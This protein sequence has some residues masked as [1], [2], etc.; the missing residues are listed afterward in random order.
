MA[1]RVYFCAVGYP[2]WTQA[3]HPPFST[4]TFVNPFAINL[5]A[6]LALVCSLP[7]AQ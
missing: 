6:T 7:Q 5:S 2:A 3:S 4:E 1:A